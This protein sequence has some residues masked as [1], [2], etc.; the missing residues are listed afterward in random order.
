M[1]AGDLD[2]RVT[3]RTPSTS[4]DAMGQPLVS[5]ADVDTVWASLRYNSGVESIKAGADTATTKASVRIRHR[6]GLSNAMQVVHG[7][8]VFNVKAVLPSQRRGYADLVC[9]VV[10]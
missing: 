2:Q 8:I 1:R 3:L 7:A 6:A 5:W 4:Q 10:T 9:E